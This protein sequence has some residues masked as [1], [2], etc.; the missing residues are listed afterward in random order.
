VLVRISVLSAFLALI[1]IAAGCG[2]GGS[3]SSSSS[4]ANS[5]AA[6]IE[7]ADGQCSGFQKER[8]PIE[9]EIEAIE[10]SA[11]PE[12]PKNL[13]RLGELLDEVIAAAEVELESIRELEPPPAD[14]ATIEKMLDTAQEGN[15][16]GSEAAEALEEGETSE[17]SELSKGIEAAN[18]RARGMAESYGLKV[19]GQAP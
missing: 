19:C 4:A 6:F 1:V 18:N 2:G 17:F 15:G 16:L 14:E 7:E 12:S 10:G 5:K 13:R 3:S 8:Q 9:E 11:D